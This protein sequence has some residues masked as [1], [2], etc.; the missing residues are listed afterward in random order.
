MSKQE[1]ESKKTSRRKFGRQMAY[2]LAALP[3]TAIATSTI[4][5]TR[6]RTKPH[7]DDNRNHE[8]TPPPIEL[9]DGSFTLLAKTTSPNHPLPE[10]GT[11]PF[12]YRGKVIP[13]NGKNA[14]EHIRVLYGNGDRIYHDSSA[15][16]SV[17]TVLL[18]DED[19]VLV[20]TLEAS[21]MVSG[22]EDSFQVVSNAQLAPSSKPGKKHKHF[23][24]HRGG[25]GN[26]DFRVAAI[27]ITKG[28][29]TKFNLTL[30]PVTASNPFE[31]QGYR[32]LIWLGD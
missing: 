13:T 29:S 23:L 18:K 26:K 25:A 19:D 9:Q 32:V 14:I 16:G 27:K 24:E 22:T 1:D 4:G 2:A 30:P 7:R 28:G 15:I 31:S 6:K 11:G 3:V 5:Q 20:G 17:I 12:T 10:T 8:N 21:S